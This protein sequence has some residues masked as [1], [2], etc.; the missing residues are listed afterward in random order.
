MSNFSALYQNQPIGL[1][2]P[3]TDLSLLPAKL[4]QKLWI[5]PAEF[6]VL[7][8]ALS[9]AEWALY[10]STAWRP[11]LPAPPR[12]GPKAIYD[13]SSIIVMALVQVAWQLSYEEV[14][15]YF[16]SHP[17]LAQA[18]GWPPNRGSV[19]ANIGNGGAL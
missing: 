3:P 2:L 9:V 13:D 16:R 18:V 6:I 5:S 7:T 12:R 15:D 11:S 14:T 10:L 8:A 17:A 1:S 19:S 4:S